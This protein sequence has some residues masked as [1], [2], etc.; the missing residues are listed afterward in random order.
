MSDFKMEHDEL[1][2]QL[3]SML[4]QL[5]PDALPAGFTARTMAFIQPSAAVVT[6]PFRLQWSDFVPAIVASFVGTVLLFVGLGLTGTYSLLEWVQVDALFGST[7]DI[8]LATI[9]AVV[10]LLVAAIPLLPSN[11]RSRNNTWL[12]ALG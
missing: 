12:L 3:D 7:N 6:E 9:F 8:Q 4:N 2:I 10:G 1:E 5:G 11:I